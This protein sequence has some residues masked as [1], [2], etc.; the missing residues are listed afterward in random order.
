[1]RLE[2]FDEGKEK[3]EIRRKEREVNLASKFA[4]P[5]VNLPKGASA[6]EL[7]HMII[8]DGLVLNL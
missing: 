4:P 5:I 7:Y 8:F 1:M 3:L 6:H 2:A